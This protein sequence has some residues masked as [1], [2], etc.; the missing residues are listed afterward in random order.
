MRGSTLTFLELLKVG[1]EILLPLGKEN[2]KMTLIKR[3]S[4][5]KFLKRSMVILVLFLF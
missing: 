1:G 2:Q 4:K 5:N 3:D